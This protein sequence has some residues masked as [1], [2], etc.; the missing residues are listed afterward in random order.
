[1][2]DAWPEATLGGAVG[3]QPRTRQGQRPRIAGAGTPA[4]LELPREAD[5]QATVWRFRQ[6]ATATHFD[7]SRPNYYLP[8]KAFGAL[9][10]A[11]A[12]VER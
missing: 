9:P 6:R 11:L 1:M 8:R 5:V 4:V 3:P 7:T 2:V 12:E 10:L